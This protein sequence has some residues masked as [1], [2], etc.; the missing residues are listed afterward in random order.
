MTYF[1]K[2]S[3]ASRIA[4]HQNISSRRGRG[5]TAFPCLHPLPGMAPCVKSSKLL[6]LR[7][8]RSKGTT[9]LKERKLLLVHYKMPSV[10]GY[11]ALLDIFHHGGKCTLES[12]K[13]FHLLLFLHSPFHLL[14]ILLKNIYIYTFNFYGP[15]HLSQ[16]YF[17]CFFGFVFVVKFPHAQCSDSVDLCWLYLM[18]CGC[19]LFLASF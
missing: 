18:A 4:H 13:V 11:F 6:N 7:H 15:V 10:K 14:N 19:L 2:K 8:C 17:H 5:L 3:S 12:V 9:V 1:K 16:K